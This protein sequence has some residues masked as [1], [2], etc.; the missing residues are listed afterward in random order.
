MGAQHESMCERSRNYSN[1][2]KMKKNDSNN[3]NNEI[4]FKNPCFGQVKALQ[5]CLF[6]IQIHGNYI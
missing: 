2:I 6:V 3:N 5:N 4:K 1:G